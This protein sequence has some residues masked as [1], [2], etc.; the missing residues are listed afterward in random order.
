MAE[1]EKENTEKWA[2]G[3]IP[4]QT[5]PVAID[6]QGEEGKNVYNQLM[7]LVKIANDV[8]KLKKLLD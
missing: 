3:E 5:E 8:E 7:L 2:L 6:T 1:K 4:T